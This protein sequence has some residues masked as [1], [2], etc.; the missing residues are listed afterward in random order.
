M[1]SSRRE[2]Q[3]QTAV[4]RALRNGNTRIKASHSD[5]RG[6]GR[7]ELSGNRDRHRR[8]GLTSRRDD[9]QRRRLDARQRA[10]SEVIEG[11]DQ[12]VADSFEREVVAA[13]TG[14]LNVIDV[15]SAAD[16]H[17]RSVDEHRD[18]R[19]TDAFEVGGLRFNP[20]V[21]IAGRQRVSEIAGVNRH[22]PVE[23]LNPTV[24]AEQN[25]HAVGSIHGISL[26]GRAKNHRRPVGV[27]AVGIVRAGIY[28]EFEGGV[29]AV[30][31]I[32]IGRDPDEIR[33][34]QHQFAWR[35]GSVQLCE[36]IQ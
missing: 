24:V 3:R 1:R 8:A 16:L 33:D 11:V 23:D 7:I 31:K 27:V 35:I 14:L 30:G 20:H 5:S 36:V 22:I 26:A 6:V 28:L 17:L 32:V 9:I 12:V 15:G 13:E 18:G 29:T 34:V 2:I 25:A 19:R 4:D 21:E 10:D